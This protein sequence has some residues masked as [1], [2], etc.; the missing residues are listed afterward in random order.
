[1]RKQR[2]KQCRIATAYISRPRTTAPAAAAPDPA[3]KATTTTA[4]SIS[5]RDRIIAVAILV[6]G[7]V[8]TFSIIPVKI[9]NIAAFIAGG[10]IPVAG[11]F[12]FV[13]LRPMFKRWTR[14][15]ISTATAPV[16]PNV[17][18]FINPGTDRQRVTY[19]QIKRAFTTGSI[20]TRDLENIASF[21]NVT[22][23]IPKDWRVTPTSSRTTNVTRTIP[24]SAHTATNQL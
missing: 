21:P 24:T 19:R 4:F 13:R 22:R 11:W 14:R 15:N 10:L 8:A 18:Q 6:V 23:T 16:I 20:T 9:V 17:R 7:T 5:I 3:P 2:S 12:A 1:M